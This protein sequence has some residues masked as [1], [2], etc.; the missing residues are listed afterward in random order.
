MDE[1]RLEIGSPTAPE[2][3]TAIDRKNG[4]EAY[5]L[6]YADDSVEEIRASHILE[7]FGHQQVPL[8]LKEWVRVLKPGGRIRIAVP[9]F[10]TIISIYVKGEPV[11][12]EGYV[13]GGQ[14]DDGD[15]H[16]S[17]FNEPKLRQQLKDAGLFKIG[18][19]LSDRKD[20]ASY[21][22]SLNLDGYKSLAGDEAPQ[23]EIDLKSV[24]GAAK[25]VEPK[26]KIT[27]TDGSLPMN[28]SAAMSVPRLAF[29]D[30]MFSA[31]GALPPLGIPLKKCAG[32]FWGQS[33][34]KCIQHILKED[35]G[36]EAILA[37]DYDTVFTQDD[38][39]ELVRLLHENPE[40]D[41]IAPVQ[42]SRRRKFPLMT[43][44]DTTRED[45]Y[46]NVPMSSFAPDLYKV[47]TAHFGLTLI[48]RSVFE[49]LK[50]PWFHSMTGPTGEWD[51]DRTDE[52]VYFWRNMASEGMSLYQANHVSVG[53][54][55]LMILWPGQNDGKFEHLYQH[56]QDFWDSGKPEGL[57]N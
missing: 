11:N 36:V 12:L 57:W 6:E 50:H 28:V 39:A 53:H 17:L 32:V 33:M 5:P 56:P 55:E 48:R 40:A 7:H 14:T 16:R 54:C 1:I 4:I 46:C 19:W 10:D 44:C 51:E 34:E 35:A 49:K 2:G 47:A 22:I 41:A 52:D 20:Y 25:R 27:V 13:M 26:R 24:A 43:V 23:P 37:I 29:M 38:V 8:V 45:V 18:K 42:M 3:W 21:S 31:V 9:N 15:C 30:N